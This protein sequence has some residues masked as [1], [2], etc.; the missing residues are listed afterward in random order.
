M[1][2]SRSHDKTAAARIDEGAAAAAVE[3]PLGGTGGSS[4]GGTR[5][6][7]GDPSGGPADLNGEGAKERIAAMEKAPDLEQ[8]SDEDIARQAGALG[9]PDGSVA[10]AQSLARGPISTD[11]PGRGDVGSG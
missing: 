3:E 1:S 8:S 9:S 2:D 4:G 11:S 6:G 10:G 7:S 5:A